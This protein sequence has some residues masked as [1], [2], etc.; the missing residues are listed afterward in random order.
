[1]PP[2]NW[3]I[4]PLPLIQQ[5]EDRHHN[6][7]AGALF[8]W[9]VWTLDS[10]HYLDDLDRFFDASPIPMAGHRP[11]VVDV[12]HARWAT[13]TSITS[14]DLCA[15]G[16]GRVFCGHMG[17]RELDIQ[18]FFSNATRRGL[19]PQVA[20]QWLGGISTDPQYRTVKSVRNSLT[21]SRLNRH[22]SMP[23]QRLRL[24]VDAIQLPVRNIVEIARDLAIHHVSDFIQ[25]LPQI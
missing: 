20:Q 2:Y 19:L 21:H 12:A 18:E 7:T 3:Q 10:L 5:F 15:A 16:L 17:P 8:A 6:P 25:L 14:L 22:F 1:M 23:Y 4:D 13:N 9:A 11:D 24:E